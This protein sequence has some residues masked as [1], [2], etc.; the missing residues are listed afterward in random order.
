[1]KP[2]YRYLKNGFVYLSIFNI[3]SA[4]IIVFNESQKQYEPLLQEASFDYESYRY[5]YPLDG[6]AYNLMVIALLVNIVVLLCKLSCAGKRKNSNG[7]MGALVYGTITQ[8]LMS[9]GGVFIYL[10]SHNSV[11]EKTNILFCI[12]IEILGKDNFLQYFSVEKT[13]YGLCIVLWIIFLS[14]VYASVRKL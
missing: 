9:V 3:L 11:F 1:M 2:I 14:G 12:P 8:L 10:T 6:Y 7:L 13:Y 4:L 5:L